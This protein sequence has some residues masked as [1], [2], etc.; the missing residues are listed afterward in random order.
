VTRHAPQ[1]GGG[2]SPS[3]RRL[4]VLC[5]LALAAAAPAGAGALTLEDAVRSAW[6]RHLGLAAGAAA[7]E[8]ARADAAAAGAGALPTLALTARGVRTDEPMMAFGLRLDQGRIGMEDFAPARLNDPAAISAVG[9]GV[10]LTQPLFA[11]GRIVAGRRALAAQ[12]RAEEKSQER[13]AQELAAGVV[14]AYFGAQVAALGVRFAD[15]LLAQARETERYV[16]ARNREGL[17][18]DADVARATAFRAQ[19]EAERATALQRLESA[20]SALVLLAGDAAADAALET[21]VEAGGEVAEPA[22]DG[23]ERP[24]LAAARLR[25]DAAQAGVA[26]ARGSLLPEIGA[27]ASL[28]T[29]RTAELDEGTSWYAVGVV[30]RW[31]LSVADARRLA[32]AKAR[33]RAAEAALGWQAREAGRDAEEA[34]RAVGAADARVGSAVEAVAAS[35]SAR[36]LRHARHRQ[37]LL[38]LTDVLDAEA[39]LAGARAL[40]LSSR[41]EARVAR[42]R[43]DLALGTPVE[44]LTP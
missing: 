4:L 6:S 2:R 21:P 24:D 26:A 44:G 14:E 27:Q 23:A 22:T 10:T 40:L 19:A 33:A 30:A 35:E 9:A 13:R 16:G 17:A 34:R 36:S 12:A 15:D 31:Q 29:L 25:R 37:G 8:A 41:L 42:A 18:L 1:S 43:L 5:A 20:R 38:P 39:G 32:A 11:G 7:V 3:A 28:E